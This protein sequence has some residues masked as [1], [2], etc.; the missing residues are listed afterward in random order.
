[1]MKRE[2][3]L[4]DARRL[5]QRIE[6]CNSTPVHLPGIERV[7][8]GAL[9]DESALAELE[10]HCDPMVESVTSIVTPYKLV[11]REFLGHDTVV[12]IRSVTVGGKRIVLCAHCREHR[13]EPRASAIFESLGPAGV[14][15]ARISSP[16]MTA[17]L[18]PTPEDVSEWAPRLAK[19]RGIPTIVEVGSAADVDAFAGGVDCLQ[20]TGSSMADMR[21]LRAAGR[22]RVP[23]CLERGPFASADELLLAAERIV[24]AGNP[25][26][27]LCQSGVRTFDARTPHLDLGEV[28]YLKW[29]S[30]L[31]VVVDICRGAASADV[32][33]PLA[34]A[35]I[36][37]G[38]DALVFEV[39]SELDRAPEGHPVL[40]PDRFARL[41]PELEPWARTAG[42]TLS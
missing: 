8:V 14:R 20:I 7:V 9:G 42:R 31:P 40:S 16:S 1:M 10:L 12:S 29:R 4:A 19:V 41:V 2:A 22:W 34:R 32:I 21:L 5:M 15:L 23:V 26:V 28:A 36:A 25:N 13:D 38:A 30:H 11:S 35:A 18:Y 6:S 33:E 37:A 39:H 27:L 17:A 24:A 3:T